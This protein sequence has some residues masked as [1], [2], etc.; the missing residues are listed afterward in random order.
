MAPI[1]SDN[2]TWKGTFTPQDSAS[3]PP[4]QSDSYNLRFAL[5]YSRYNDFKGNPGHR[6]DNYKYSQAFIADTKDP[7]VAS[8][9]LVHDGEEEQTTNGI[10]MPIES[11]IKVNFDYIMDPNFIDTTTSGS[12]CAGSVNLSSDDIS[13]CSPSSSCSCVTVSYTHLT[14]PTIL[15]V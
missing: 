7:Y 8:V 5:Y 11:N 1:D 9:Y 3:M 12:N 6:P 4:S 2:T 15:L 10:C 13:T 14:L